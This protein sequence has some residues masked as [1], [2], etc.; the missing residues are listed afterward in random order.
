MSDKMNFSALLEKIS[1]KTGEKPDVILE[2]KKQMGIELR[3]SLERDGST[4]LNGLGTFYLKW[5]EEREGINPQSGEKIDIP[6]HNHIT[7]RPDAAVR[8]RINKD[9]E[10]LKA[11]ILDENDEKVVVE[12]KAKIPLWMWILLAIL[13]LALLFS[14]MSPPKE[15]VVIDEVD[16]V[17][18]NDVVVVEEV[19]VERE[20]AVVEEVFVTNEVPVVEYVGVPVPVVEYIEAPA[21]PAASDSTKAPA[22]P[23]ND[24]EAGA[25]V[26]PDIAAA[27]AGMAQGQAEEAV[28][29]AKVADAKAQAADAAQEKQNSFYGADVAQKKDAKAAEADQKAK[30]ALLESLKAD[31]KADAAAKAQEEM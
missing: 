22:S 14:L 12:Q 5:S 9:Y 26:D 25:F 23:P 10:N 7:F 28:E 8:R 6:A 2:L 11:F 4:H 21:T 15:I 30:E 17:V 20:V 1:K 13:A 29:A 31:A 19:I 24:G 3:E 18:T 16:T 27:E